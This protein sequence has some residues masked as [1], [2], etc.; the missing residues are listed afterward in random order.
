MPWFH[1][2]LSYVRSRSERPLEVTVDF[3]SP[4]FIQEEQI[5]ETVSSAP[6][7]DTSDKGGIDNNE[8]A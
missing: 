2:F 6:G 5:E 1:L 4:C 8:E 7:A 3:K